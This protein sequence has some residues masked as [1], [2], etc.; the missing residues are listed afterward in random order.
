MIFNVQASSNISEYFPKLALFAA[1]AFRIMPSI[2]RLIVNFQALR[3]SVSGVDKLHKEFPL[4]S[5]LSYMS[6]PE[7]KID[8]NR[9]VNISNISFKYPSNNKYI[10]QDV[11]LKIRTGESIG[12]TGKTGEGKS[13]FID[14]ICGLLEP[15]EGKIL[16]DNNDIQKNIKSWQQK[17]GYVPQNIYLLDD[18]ISEN[19]I[20]GKKIDKETDKNLS[21]SIKLAQLDKL[22]SKLPE[23][24][25]TVVGDRGTRLSGGQV[26]RIGIAR[27]IMS[28]AQVLV[29][30]EATSALDIETEKKLYSLLKER[31]LSLI[32]VGHRPSLKDFHENI[33]EL[34]GQGDWKLLTSDK[35]N[36]KD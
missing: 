5:E 15:Q 10:L 17:I 8:F 16:V 18:T 1:A 22:I 29:F 6:N 28:D 30:D 35:Y 9:E 33:L 20:F 21:N 3:F 14:L 11:N 7:T 13:T 31:E 36:F 4:K 12:I 32:S 26:Q 34:N 2:S 25:N 27:A 23:G 19:I 24:L